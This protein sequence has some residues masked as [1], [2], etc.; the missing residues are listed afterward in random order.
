LDIKEFALPY[1]YQGFGAGPFTPMQRL[2]VAIVL[3]VL[4]AAYFAIIV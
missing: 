4:I 2:C 1:K 3:C